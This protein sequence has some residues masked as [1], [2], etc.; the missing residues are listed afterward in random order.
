MLNIKNK[1]IIINKMNDFW[2]IGIAESKKDKK[3]EYPITPRVSKGKG[4][5]ES[6][7]N[8][9]FRIYRSYSVECSFLP[10]NFVPTIKPKQSVRQVNPLH[11]TNEIINE[12]NNMSEDENENKKKKRAKFYEKCVGKICNLSI[13]I[14]TRNNSGK[15]FSYQDSII[16]KLKEKRKSSFFLHNNNKNKKTTILMKLNRKR[17]FPSSSK[18]GI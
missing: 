4:D 14:V 7:N 10:S 16:K 6:D 2:R 5:D 8:N 9:N 11:L 1:L 13:H 17:T 3:Q 18:I 12:K 15:F